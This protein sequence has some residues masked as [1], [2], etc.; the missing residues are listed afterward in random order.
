LS[1]LRRRR[2]SDA[3]HRHTEAFQKI[4]PKKGKLKGFPK[5]LL[6]SFAACNF[7]HSFRSDDKEYWDV[8]IGI[9]I[10]GVREARYSADLTKAPSVKTHTDLY[11]MFDI[12]PFAFTRNKESLVPHLLAGM[13]L[14]GQPFHR[15]LF[16]VAEHFTKI[17]GLNKLG[18]PLPIY[19]FAGVVDNRVNDIR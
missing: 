15:P 7:S 4:T 6:F 12:Y 11:G 3:T 19:V 8:S 1:L 5:Y 18:F 2:E 14:T 17:I 16:G 9:S 13:P 10:P